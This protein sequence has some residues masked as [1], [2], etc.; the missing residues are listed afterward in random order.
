M[1][2]SNSKS[3]AVRKDGRYNQNCDLHADKGEYEKWNQ[4]QNRRWSFHH[5]HTI[6]R[7]GFSLRAPEFLPL[8]LGLPPEIEQF[9]S[10]RERLLRTSIC[11]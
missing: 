1:I 3:N 10:V 6:V 8:E 7:Y 5:L 2:Y 11:H 9:D 4:P